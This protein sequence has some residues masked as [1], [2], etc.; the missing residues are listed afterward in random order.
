MAM[1]A[2]VH[3]E[4]SRNQPISAGARNQW[5]AQILS[6]PANLQSHNYLEQAVQQ[7]DLPDLLTLSCPHTVRTKPL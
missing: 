4:M 5:N 1:Q 7:I 2:G 3:R 6:H